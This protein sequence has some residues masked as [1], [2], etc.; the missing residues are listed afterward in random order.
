MEELAIWPEL[1]AFREEM[2]AWIVEHAPSGPTGPEQPASRDW[3]RRLLEARLICPQWPEEVG[4]R[5][6]DWP[7]LA[8]FDEECRRVGVMRITRGVGESLVGPSVIVHGTGEQRALLLP[9]IVQGRDRCCTGFSE[10]EHGSDLAGVETRGEVADDHLVVSGV[11]AWVYG[12]DVASAIFVLCRTDPDGPRYRNL[13][14]A[15]VPMRGSGVEVR[16]VRH[17][18][19]AAGTFE[20]V[21]DRARAPLDNVVGGLGGG[22]RVA[23]TALAFQRADRAALCH[24]DHERELWDLVRTARRLGRHRDPL[25]RQQLAWAYGQVRI[26]RIQGMRLL[27]Q[28]AVKREPGPE[29]SLIGLF[30]TEYHRRLGEIAVDLMGAD[31]LV[32]PGGDGYATNRWQE[33]FFS[34]RAKAIAAGTS[35]IQRNIIAERALGLPGEL[36]TS[37]RDV[38]EVAGGSARR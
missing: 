6:W 7:R 36:S 38:E 35:E 19:G 16:P 8:I 14:C 26:M 12:A 23:M 32:R 17:M 5:G 30:Q 22:W 18:T 11:K 29:A 27:G 33:V 24:L 2:R 31:A 34:G 13:T 1:Q 10:P 21:L 15:L 4:G 25:V 20:V 28:I 3:E 37:A 9:P